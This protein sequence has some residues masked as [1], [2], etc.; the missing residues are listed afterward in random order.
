MKGTAMDGF[1][2]D[3][4][5]GVRMLIGSPV[6][7]LI[8]IVAFSLG[9]GLTTTVFSIVNG[10]M[11]KGLPFP[12][13]DRIVSVWRNNPDR[14][15]ERGGVSLH[16][17]VDY[18]DQQ[19]TLQAFGLWGGGAVNLVGADDE[20][21]RYDG[22]LV[23]A[24]MFE[25]LR[26]APALGRGFLPGEDEPGADRVLILG[27]EVWQEKYDGSPD[28]IGMSV[29]TN[30]E[31]RTIVGVAPEGFQ[32]PI[33][34]ELWAP[35]E[36]DPLE[37]QRGQG[38]QYPAFGRLKD[39]VSLDAASVDFAT[40]GMR[41]ESEYPEPNEGFAPLVEPYTKFVV[42]DEIFGLLMTMLGAAIGVLLIACANVA[43][44][45]FS[46]AAVRE[47]EVAV[48]SAMGAGRRRIIRQLLVEV[49]VLSAVGAAF[50]VLIGLAGVAWFNRAV[51]TNPPPFWMTF[52]PDGRVMVFVIAVTVVSA[53]AAGLFPSLRATGRG[54]NEALKDEGRG[55]SGLR[56]GRI[57]SIIVIAEIAV[58]CG[59]LIAAGLM[60]KSVT[61]LRTVDFPFAVE[62]IFTARLNLPETD[63]EDAGARTAF[64]REFLQ[65]LQA[66]PGVEAATLSDGLPA[67]GNGS[68]VFE[69][70]G[71]DYP[72]DRDYPSAREG[73]VTPGYFATFQTQIL[74]GRAFE[75]ADTRDN[76]PV[77]LVN[78]SFVREFFEGDEPLGKRFR[79]HQGEDVYEWMTVVGVVPDMKM[80][81]IGN[82]D[83]S[84]A[85][86]YIAVEQFAE[87]LGNTVS[88]G[89]R[90]AGDPGAMASRI[91]ETL[92]TMD[93]NLPLYNALTMKRVVDD[94]T[95][96]YRTF[97]TLFMAFGFVALFL[98]AVGLYGVM[99]FSVSQRTR[100]MGIRMALG[101]DNTRLIRLAM[102]RGMRQLAIGI[103]LGIGLAALA[104]RQLQIILYEVDAR[105]PVIFGGV[106][107]ALAIVG[108]LATYIPARRVSRIHPA[109]AL[110]PG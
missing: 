71:G 63:Y 83:A 25:I 6:L 14:D 44:L 47:K 35:L 85:G 39:G 10:A 79:I 103:T 59:L 89:V 51:A 104:T 60:I 81:G 40:I 97:G 96:F 4:R 76:L 41:L 55:S 17:Y 3:V 21:E 24:N 7:S 95:W 11:Y 82:N 109:E 61:Q 15:I 72:T 73:I 87:I 18:R 77:A 57:T 36:V 69:I 75:F 78:Q 42:G 94:Q 32:F 105:D 20:P 65:R 48:R 70:E 93:P 90:V 49:G 50:G 101:G 98:A 56:M 102:R 62:G 19:S 27:Y 33:E 45:L 68:R 37:H 28:V 30:G 52:D 38:P 43:N 100:E 80:E 22:A 99:S 91:R 8:A 31:P 106:V 1:F 53:I 58:S 54:M 107:L 88:V 34:A 86:Y 9:I 12:E 5:Y 23:T 74:D 84:P 29:R 13:G 64:Y 110:S 2:K 108:L 46:R 67:R 16:D 92:T 26:V 66:T